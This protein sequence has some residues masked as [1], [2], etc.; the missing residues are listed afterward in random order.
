MSKIEIYKRQESLSKYKEPKDFISM[1]PANATIELRH[2]KS[3]NDI[4][5]S[6]KNQE[7][8]SISTLKKHHGEEKVIAYLFL[9]ILDLNM[10][11]G[12]KNT[13]SEPQINECAF[14]IIEDYYYLK[15]ADFKLFFTN[16]KKGK[17]GILYE[18]LSTPKIL[19]WLEKYVIERTLMFENSEILEE[20]RS[21]KEEAECKLGSIKSIKESLEIRKQLKR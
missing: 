7:T 10:A 3:E 17:L 2:I 15:I 4:L 12:V 18:S 19:E 16:I 11:L 8:P 21:K 14:F 1:S 6:V 5:L 20:K 9:W 13:M